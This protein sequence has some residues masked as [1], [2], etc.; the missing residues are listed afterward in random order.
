MLKRT[1]L[2][3]VKGYQALSRWALPPSCRF[4]PSCSEYTKQAIVKYG[5]L[6]GIL[7]GVR[8]ISSCHPFSGRFGYDPLD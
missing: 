8:R 1:A 2:F 4:V 7:K 3:L 5:L 6:K